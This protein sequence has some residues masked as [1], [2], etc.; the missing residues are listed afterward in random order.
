LLRYDGSIE[1]ERGEGGYAKAVV[2]RL[3][4]SQTATSSMGE[5]A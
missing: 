3:F 1:V 2:V 5:A 4:R